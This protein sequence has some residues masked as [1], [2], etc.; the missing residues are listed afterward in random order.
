MDRGKP[1]PPGKGLR[2]VEPERK[3]K[4]KRRLQWQQHTHKDFL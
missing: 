3:Q 2:P 4:R 1:Y